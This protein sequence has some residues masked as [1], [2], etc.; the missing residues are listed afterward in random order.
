LVDTLKLFPEVHSMAKTR[1][2]DSPESRRQMVELGRAGRDPDDVAG[3]FEPTAQSIR[4]WIAR[5]D[6]KDGRQAD[7]L[8]ALNAAERDELS[9]PWAS[10]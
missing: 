7:A 10:R 4:H 8:P 3:E 6:K 9:R 1:L 5:A 2:P